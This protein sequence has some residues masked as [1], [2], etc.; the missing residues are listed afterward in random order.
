MNY[1]KFKE[2]KP[3][4]KGKDLCVFCQNPTCKFLYT[5]DVDKL[6]EGTTAVKIPFDEEAHID[7]RYFLGV[8][9]CAYFV[10]GIKKF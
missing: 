10:H 5:E 3:D 8:Y 9:D 1:N 4:L 6:P 7:R 2:L